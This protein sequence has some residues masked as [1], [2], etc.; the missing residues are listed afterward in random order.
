KAQPKSQS[1]WSRL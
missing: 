1:V